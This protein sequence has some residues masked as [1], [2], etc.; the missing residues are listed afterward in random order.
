MKDNVETASGSQMNIWSQKQKIKRL[1]ILLLR[2][3]CL[4]LN[5]VKIKQI[6]KLRSENSFFF[7]EFNFNQKL[8]VVQML[9]VAF[10]TFY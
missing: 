4:K 5:T 6:L 1:G 10:A 7:A 9:R 3:F 2:S 8:C